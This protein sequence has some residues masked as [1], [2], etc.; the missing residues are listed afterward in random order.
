MSQRRDNYRAWYESARSR[1]LAAQSLESEEAIDWAIAAS[2]AHESS[3]P[4]D[5]RR[6]LAQSDLLKCLARG[7]ACGG[8]SAEGGGVFGGEAGGSFKAGGRGDFE[9]RRQERILRQEAGGRGQ[10]VDDER[11]EL[12]VGR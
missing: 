2:V 7:D 12:E 5:I 1:V 4:K 10:E 8:V 11:R 3:D 9:G 6:V